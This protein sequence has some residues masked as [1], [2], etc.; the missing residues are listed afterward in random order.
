MHRGIEA[1]RAAVRADND[2]ELLKDRGAHS[3]A[4]VDDQRGLLRR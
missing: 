1:G 4:A 3:P 2:A